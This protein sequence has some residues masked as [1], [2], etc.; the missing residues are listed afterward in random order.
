[1]TASEKAKMNKAK[2]DLKQKLDKI[3]VEVDSDNEVSN[4][5]DIFFV[6]TSKQALNYDSDN[7]NSMKLETVTESPE[8]V[9]IYDSDE[10]EP[11]EEPKVE[12][13]SFKKQQVSNKNIKTK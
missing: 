3:H 8:N 10:E 9:K 12:A 6:H 7:D 1:M 5:N 4:E 11:K 13:K 2:K